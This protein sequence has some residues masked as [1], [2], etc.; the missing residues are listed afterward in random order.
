MARS[1]TDNRGRKGTNAETKPRQ[2]AGTVNTS[3]SETG[4]AAFR[5]AVRS[6]LLR[7]YDT[8]KRDLPWR[9][10]QDDPYAQLLAEYMLQQTQ[11]ATVIRYYDRFIRRFPTVA[12]LAAA[13]LD[14]VLTLWAGL[15][16]YRRARNLHAAARRIV[17][18]HDARVPATVEQLMALPGIGRYTAGAIAS[19]AFGE[20]AP[21]L[22]GNVTRVLTRL[23]AI[24]D[25]PKSPAVRSRLWDVAESLLPENRCG[26]F[27][28][29]MMEVGA[30]VCTPR[31]PGCSACP[32]RSRC[33]TAGKGLTD[34][35]PVTS[36]R[37]GIKQM[38]IVV[39]AIT[40]GDSIL[41]VQRPEEGLWAGLWE[42]P[43]ETV[44]DGERIEVARRRLAKRLGSAYRLVRKP[45]APIVRQLTHRQV[46][47]HT[48]LGQ[49]GR[50]PRIAQLSGLP[51][52]WVKPG[53]RP[54]LGVSKAHRAIIESI[55]RVSRAGREG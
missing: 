9:H 21:V 51:C 15:G 1:K 49:A 54:Q 32:L 14:E 17:A 39:A 31:L 27:N 48:F 44:A 20:R 38:S 30:V 41:L 25:D 18:E 7:W 4:N 23:L 36:R 22:D 2:A 45:T 16:Y 29:A 11:V 35:I 42:L 43:S 8:H 19:V 5:L 13:D 50:K 33:Q 10:R 53:E 52:R 47:F 34:R 26:D 6:R 12:A 24:E 3:R 46:T 37:T 55:G 40:H 28:Q